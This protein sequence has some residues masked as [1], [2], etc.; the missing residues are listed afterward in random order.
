MASLHCFGKM[1]FLQLFS[2]IKMSSLQILQ[3]I[4]TFQIKKN[5]GCLFFGFACCRV[6]WSFRPIQLRN[7]QQPPSSDICHVCSFHW[8]LMK[9]LKGRPIHPLTFALIFAPINVWTEASFNAVNPF[10]PTQR[11]KY[12]SLLSRPSK[13][14]QSTHS[15]ATTGLFYFFL[16]ISSLFPEIHFGN[17]LRESFLGIFSENLLKYSSYGGKRGRLPQAKRHQPSPLYSS[18]IFWD[19]DWFE[20]NMEGGFDFYCSQILHQYTVV[21]KSKVCAELQNVTD[22]TDISV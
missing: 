2:F 11:S 12:M 18:S 7:D 1:C 9:R 22:M 8:A 15:I 5:K 4:S 13:I 3:S 17:L 16:R 6:C 14:L 20:G 21:L 19:G 10:P